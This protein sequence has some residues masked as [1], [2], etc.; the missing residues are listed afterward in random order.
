MNTREI[1]DSSIV[2]SPPPFRDIDDLIARERRRDRVRRLTAVAGTAGVV[3]VVA[4][5][6]LVAGNLGLARPQGGPAAEETT[7]VTRSI[8]PDETPQAWY[9]RLA[10]LLRTRVVAVLPGATLE[11]ATS[12]MFGDSSMTFP[13]YDDATAG[14][15]ITT[16]EGSASLGVFVVRPLAPPQP[17]PTQGVAGRLFGGCAGTWSTATPA[18]AGPDRCEDRTGPGGT[19][20]SV[21]E[22]HLGEDSARVVT[23]AF[24]DGGVVSVMTELSAT[25]LS[26]DDLVAIFADPDFVAGNATS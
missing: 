16:P 25:W 3:A 17:Q 22:R 14:V 2:D 19:A 20:V 4:G 18:T 15:T 7:S 24:P 10:E 8:P 5:G 23:I 11:S 1:L 21:A 26:P 9:A 6:A 12:D 13:G